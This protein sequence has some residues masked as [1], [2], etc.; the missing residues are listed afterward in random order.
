MLPSPKEPNF[1]AE[2]QSVASLISHLHHYFANTHSHYKAEKS[3]LLSQVHGSPDP[4]TQQQSQDALNQLEAE[5]AI[6]GALSDALSVADRLLHA[7]TVIN[8]LGP[9]SGIYT[10]RHQP[11]EAS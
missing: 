9:N 8:E 1:L 5:I 2:N 11:P 3:M 7:R 6:F 4:A 10:T